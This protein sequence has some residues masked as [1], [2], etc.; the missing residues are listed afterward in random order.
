MDKEVDWNFVS[1]LYGVV[2][3]KEQFSEHKYTISG[4]LYALNGG[5]RVTTKDNKSIFIPYSNIKG[6]ELGYMEG[7]ER[8]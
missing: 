8:I 4:H 1:D 2:Y 6:I 3:L 5:Y 7:I